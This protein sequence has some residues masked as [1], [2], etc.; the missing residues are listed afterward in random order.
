MIQRKLADM[1]TRIYVADS[2]SYRT[3][4]LHGRRRATAID[5]RAPRRRRSGSSTRRSRS[6]RS[7]LDPEGVRHRDARLRRRRG[8]AD[9]RRLRLHR[10]LPDRAPLPRLAHQP[11]LRG[12]ERDQ[13]PDH[14]GD[15]GEAHRPRARSPYLDFLQQVEREIAEPRAWPPAAAGPLER[16]LRAAEVAKR[17]VAYT[18]R[19]LIERDL[20]SLKDKQQHLEILANMIIDVYAMDS[21]VNRTRLLAGPRRDRGRRA[22]A[23][24]D[25][26]LRRVGERAR[27][28]RRAPAPRER[29]RG[30]GAARSTWRSR[31]SCRASRSAP[32]P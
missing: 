31:R 15:A 5:P 1:A 12:H 23:R 21:V 16:E 4:G 3:A 8:A 30:R 25:E 10:R 20:A 18:A 7:R 2:M 11:H 9:P 14:P 6:T 26:R 32:S 19:V 13:P 28:R 24:D 29:V 27:D 22:P 17:V